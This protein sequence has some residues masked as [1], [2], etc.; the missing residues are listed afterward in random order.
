MSNSGILSK[1]AF[2]LDVDGVICRGSKPIA[3]GVEGVKKL[4]D[5]GKK[6]VFVSNNSTRSRRMLIERFR[7]FG[8]EVE[9]KSLIVAT[10]ATASYLR[11][12]GKLDVF[13][14]GE[15][16]LIEELELAG[17]RIVDYDDAECLVVASNRKLDYDLMTK[18]LRCCLRVERYVATNPDKIFPGFMGPI[19][20]TGMIIGALYWM[21]N[22][23][24][25]AVIGKP[26][27]IIMK[28]AL[29][30]LGCNASEVAVVGDQIDVDVAAGRKVGCQ[31]VL[32]LSGVTTP[33]NLGEVVERYGKPD[34][35]VKDLASIFKSP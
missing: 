30:V 19:P 17:H 25:D 35:I 10:Y 24:P 15:E 33:E 32:V 18:A 9:E 20:G 8:I 21:T 5:M 27:E 13:T 6:V 29:R 1:K 31:T 16:G 7:G 12:F 2:I 14:T 11:K 3:A 28:E 34:F 4:L 23:M 26:S 22:R